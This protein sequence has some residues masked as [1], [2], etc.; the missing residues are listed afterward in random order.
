MNVGI[1]LCFRKRKNCGTSSEVCVVILAKV[2]FIRRICVLWDDVTVS[3]LFS[4]KRESV[5]AN[6]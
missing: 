5:A 4:V 3:V 2:G 6:F 1:M